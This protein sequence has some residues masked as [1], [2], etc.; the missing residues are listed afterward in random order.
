M[1]LDE[2]CPVCGR[3]PCAWPCPLCGNDRGDQPQVCAGCA[4]RGR[5]DLRDLPGLAARLAAEARAEARTIA[6][7]VSGS[8]ET[9]LPLRT[10]LWSFIGL[11]PPGDI[12]AP[13]QGD[14]DCQVG[15]LPLADVLWMWV[16][17]A[18]ADLA[19]SAPRVRR[20]H[21]ER[22]VRVFAGILAA[23]H[24]RICRLPWAAEYLDEVHRLWA[25][26]RTL[27]VDWPLVHRL[28]APCP[29]LDCGLLT[30]RRDDGADHVYCATR[31]GGCGR[32]WTE[33]EYRRLIFILVSE[34]RETGWAS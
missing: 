33:A 20:Q 16:D 31:D 2:P 8:R 9:P 13:E 28:A 10:D 15:D 23:Q 34:A 14:A 25:R 24:D 3:N 5:R 12:T 1:T 18:A 6:D 17:N 27:L 21:P 4:N 11:G 19:I 22:A 30:L 32:C 26:A 7:P 29:S